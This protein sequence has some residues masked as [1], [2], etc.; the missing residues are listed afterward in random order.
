MVEALYIRWVLT[1]L[2]T[3]QQDLDN[4]SGEGSPAN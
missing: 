1:P 4:R 3:I 2:P